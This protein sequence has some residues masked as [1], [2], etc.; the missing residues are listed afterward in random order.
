[1]KILG[2]SCGFDDEA[3][4]S[5]FQNPNAVKDTHL[6]LKW[7]AWPSKAYNVQGTRLK[8]A[9]L[10]DTHMKPFDVLGLK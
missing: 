8:P 3:M 9:A 4:S 7:C 5:S 6:K 10:Q 2:L 1:M